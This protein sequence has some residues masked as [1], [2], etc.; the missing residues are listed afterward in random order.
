MASSR[1][2][3]LLPKEHGTYG[4]LLFPLITALGI[5]GVTTG[6]VLVALAALAGYLAHES[7]AVLAGLR[8]PRARRDHA[9][10]ARWGLATLGTLC[11]ILGGAGLAAL[12]AD[13]RLALLAP[14]VLSVAT[15]AAAWLGRVRS[16]WGEAV[17]A[18][19]LS[20]WSLPVAL[21]GRASL[22]AALAC[23]GIWAAV[24]IAG[25]LAVRALIA[26]TRRQPA[27]PEALASALVSAG[28][29]AGALWLVQL[30]RLP[31]GV[32]VA[33]VPTT[34]AAG[35]LGV[36]GITARHLRRVGWTLVT[37]SIGT[38]CALVATL[39]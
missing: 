29:F 39:R 24:F 32:L 15:L 30:D 25:T 31:P 4:E 38:L 16:A 8:G 27:W 34:L 7:V 17:A 14:S 26:R 22:M 13:A 9:P 37:A 18:A 1:A 5:G 36:P 12:P 20:A 10:E 35:V 2:R 19:A 23:W 6:G 28:A 21:A 3:L 33:F 11:A